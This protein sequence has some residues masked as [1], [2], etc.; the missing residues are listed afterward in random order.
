M[1]TLVM[2][3]FRLYDEGI[4]FTLH[5][6]DNTVIFGQ[7]QDRDFVLEK[8]ADL[9]AKVSGHYQYQYIKMSK[10]FPRPEPARPSRAT[11]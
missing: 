6:P 10:Y 7:V 4:L 2:S 1:V 9:L 5:S 11:R 3:Y 8:I